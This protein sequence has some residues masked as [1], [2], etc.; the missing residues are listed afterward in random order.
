MATIQGT[1]GN[2]VFTGTWLSAKV[3]QWEATIE[4]SVYDTSGFSSNGWEEGSTGGIYQMTGTI[5]GTAQTDAPPIAAGFFADPCGLSSA[6]G[7]II[8]TASSTA[9]ACTYTFNA[10]CRNIKMSR[11]HNGKMDITF[12]F[13]SNGT[14]ATVW[15]QA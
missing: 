4:T 5:S 12:D 14:I 9:T 2:V 6:K 11:P 7:Q 8:L 10:V 13:V 1:G 3:A 15:D